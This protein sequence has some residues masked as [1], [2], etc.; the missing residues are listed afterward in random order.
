[1]GVF[2]QQLRRLFC[3]LFEWCPD[4]SHPK[5]DAQRCCF[6]DAICRSL[7]EYNQHI[8]SLKE[9]MEEATESAKEIR[10]EIQAFRNK[11]VFDCHAQ[12]FAVFSALVT[13]LHNN[14][15]QSKT[16]ACSFSS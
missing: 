16:K 14:H 8:E 2:T 3:V 15:P 4:C 1:M 10:A 13:Y 5:S 11:C 6:Q 12:R 9:E 7:Q